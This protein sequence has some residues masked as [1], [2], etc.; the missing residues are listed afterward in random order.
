MEHEHDFTQNTTFSAVQTLKT[1]TGL[2]SDSEATSLFSFPPRRQTARVRPPAHLL[3]GAD[4]VLRGLA[5]VAPDGG[6]PSPLVGRLR[7]VV[8]AH[9][10]G[11]TG[12]GWPAQLIVH[13][14]VDCKHVQA[15]RRGEKK[16]QT[17]L[18]STLFATCKLPIMR[19][20]HE[21]WT[22]FRSSANFIN[23]LLNVLTQAVFKLTQ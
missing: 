6:G 13:D 12:F 10:Y 23:S 16:K 5:D 22:E 14:K 11:V 7:A 9:L 17:K 21:L 19:S 4:E 1:A 15:L 3:H 18:G 20:S 8:A 2:A